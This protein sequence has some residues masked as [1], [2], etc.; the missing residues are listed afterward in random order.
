MFSSACTSSSSVARERV[1]LLADRHR[2]GVLQL[3]AAH[4]HD[5]RELLALGAERV[6]QLLELGDQLAV[7]ERHADVIAVGYESFV[8]CDRFTWSCG[9]QNLYSPFLWPISSSA[10]FAITSFAFM[11]VE[12]PAPPWNHVEPELI[13]E[14][15]VDDLLAGAFDR[16][17][18][19]LRESADSMLA[20]AA[21]SFT[22]ARP[23]MNFGIVLQLDAGD[24]EVLERARRLHAVVRVRRNGEIAEQVVL[25]PRCL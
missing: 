13:V 16:R 4:L 7:A 21:A 14:L 20:R 2:H 5:V 22:I 15:A 1:E 17:E 19:L 25:D 12:V 8:D 11:F 23:L 3:G 10:R 6:D 9:S 24:L 18:D